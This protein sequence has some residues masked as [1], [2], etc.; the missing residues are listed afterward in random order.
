M[1]FDGVNDGRSS[2]NDE[3]APTLPRGVRRRILIRGPITDIAFSPDGLTFTMRVDDKNWRWELATGKLLDR[4][5][6]TAP[7]A[8]LREIVFP[9]GK[10]LAR[11]DSKRPAF[12]DVI[13]TVTGKA[14]F[15]LMGE[16]KPFFCV[17]VSPDG[18]IIA[19]GSKEKSIYWWETATGQK[20]HELYGHDGFVTALAFSPDGRT[21]V[22]GAEDG[23]V[24][25]WDVHAAGSPLDQAARRL[26]DSKLNEW[27]ET[28]RGNH[29]APAYRAV[30]I[31]AASPEKSIPFLKKHASKRLDTDRVRKLIADLDSEEFAV[32]KEAA[33]ELTRLGRAIETMLHKALAGNPSLETR[34]RIERL[35][36]GMEQEDLLAS[37]RW[38][39]AMIVLERVASKEALAVL[40]DLANGS[41]GER[42]TAGARA[43][44]ARLKRTAG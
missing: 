21:L 6:V 22:S 29:S 8:S 28:L 25:V 10:L 37:L 17:A 30:R 7:V 39:R 34:R 5:I 43:A 3:Q 14:R 20:I 23:T 18:K 12:I 36:D 15:D 11:L 33:D 38:N 4:A 19:A 13:D 40:D 24:F 26:D 27:W 9:D 32:R 2:A 41:G 31:L 16:G 1:Y 42:V 35:L 44:L